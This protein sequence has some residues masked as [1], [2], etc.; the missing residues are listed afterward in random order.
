MFNE[1]AHRADIF[2]NKFFRLVTL[3]NVISEKKI[4]ITE[5]SIMK[6]VKYNNAYLFFAQITLLTS[7]QHYCIRGTCTY[8]LYNVYTW[9]RFALNRICSML[10]CGCF[11]LS[12]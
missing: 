12:N 10:Q 7:V 4:I 11:Y 2:T 1:S 6:S 8:E 3:C 5:S 9:T